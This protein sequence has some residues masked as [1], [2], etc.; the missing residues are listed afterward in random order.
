MRT[1][2]QWAALYRSGAAS[3]VEAADECIRAIDERDTAIGAFLTVTPE[4]A[5]ESAKASEGRWRRGE[6]LSPI[7]GVPLAMKDLSATK[8]VRTTFGSKPFEGFVPD[9]DIAYWARLKEAGAV[10]AGKTNTPEFGSMPTTEN[11][12]APPTRNPWDASKTAGGSSGGSAAAIAAGFVPLAEGS[13]AGGSIR[14]PASCCGVV[15]IKPSRGRV[16]EG[17]NFPEQIAGLATSGP[18][19]TTVE[20]CLAMLHAMSGNDPGDPYP[21]ARRSEPRPI[22]LVGLVEEAPHA[23]VDPEVRE[24]VGRI[25]WE[26]ESIGVPVE[27]ADLPLD[28]FAEDVLTAFSV[29][30]AALP[31]PDHEVLHPITR[32]MVER[33]QATTAAAYERCRARLH[34]R[35][36]ALR[37]AMA[38][39]DAVILPV[40]TTPPKPL[41]FLDWQPVEAAF[42][43][44]PY[45]YPFNATGQPCIAVPAGTSRDGLPIGAQLVGRYGED[46]TVASLAARWEA[47]RGLPHPS[48]TDRL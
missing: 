5:R 7:D 43:W 28:G 47:A 11:L 13:D 18:M 21:A 15:G 41:G 10:L 27:P 24:A 44:L 40:L 39:Y 9:F 17:P 19:G 23:R 36:R 42:E 31:L 32:Q 8:G 29:G 34:R 38:H 22:R 14:I 2:L 35:S 46:E 33:G 48:A 6:P 12:I 37:L 30:M 45:T 3:P 4:A 20:D 16:S 26:I 25:A 1:A